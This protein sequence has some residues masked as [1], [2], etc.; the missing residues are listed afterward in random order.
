[1]IQ[2]RE[3][4]AEAIALVIR[5]IWLPEFMQKVF[6]DQADAFGIDFRGSGDFIEKPLVIWISISLVNVGYG[7]RLRECFTIDRERF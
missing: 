6:I 3:P 1:M 2:N 5:G 4:D 7:N